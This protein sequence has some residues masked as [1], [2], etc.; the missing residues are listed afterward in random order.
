MMRDSL[1]IEK[2]IRY[3]SWPLGQLPTEFQRREPEL[4]RKDGYI[5]DDPRD[6]VD[7]F[8]SKLAKF[9]NSKYAIV[10]DCASHA[11]FLSLKYRKATGPIVIPA[12]T[13]ASVPMQIIHAGA[14]PVFEDIRWSG[15]YELSPWKIIDSAAR[16]TRDMYLD[17]ESLQILS[18]QIKKRLPIG[19]G[20]AI[21]TDS[22]E[23]YEWFKLAIYDGR[24]LKSPYDH[25]DHVKTI[26][27][28][29]Y[30]TPED[31][32][33]GIWLMDRIPEI[34]PDTMDWSHYPDLRQWKPFRK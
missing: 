32:A 4:I 30:M 15:V 16:F 17:P 28:H 5:W 9:A 24:D 13:Y 19:R 12:N 6:I 33:R 1:P 8:E 3:N 31:A 11:L 10:T 2:S 25:P 22:L 26:G 18:F 23:A 34:N 21:L 14:I 29:F 20:G 7:L 27:W